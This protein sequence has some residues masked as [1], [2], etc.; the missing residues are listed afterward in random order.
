MTVT[1][2][3]FSLYQP[4]GRISPRSILVLL[5][6]G[7][8]GALLLG[9]FYDFARG[10]AHGSIAATICT[11]IFIVITLVLSTVLCEA[12]HSRSRR[13]N[14]VSAFALVLLMMSVRWYLP[15]QDLL[16]QSNVHGL[17]SL[18]DVIAIVSSSLADHG[19]TANLGWAMETFCMFLLP[20]F[21]AGKGASDPY[22]E[23]AR[24]WAEKHIEAELYW[25]GGNS[26]DVL[27]KLK[28]E[29]VFAMLNM[30]R[31]IDLSASSLAS[32]WWTLK[33]TGKR[34][35]ADPDARWITVQIVTF[36]RESDGKVKSVSDVVL[37]HWHLPVHEY[38]AL[39]DHIGNPA[40]SPPT[41]PATESSETPKELV[42]ALAALQSDNFAEAIELANS[43]AHDSNHL[44]AADARRICAQAHARLSQWQESFG[45]YKRLF[46]LEPSALN[47]LQLA[48]TAV[49]SADTPL[50]DSWFE[51][52][53]AININSNELPQG[54]L[55]TAYLSALEQAGDYAATRPHLDWLACAYRSVKV[56]DDHF[57][58]ARGLPFF[59]EFLKK[60]QP[61][62]LACVPEH[63]V[64]AW[65]EALCPD[66]DEAGR[67]AVKQHL[68]SLSRAEP[69]AQL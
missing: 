29:G 53:Q 39:A 64:R 2:A 30:P 52:A 25:S 31:A 51:R 1:T 3:D 37:E 11:S 20:V 65:Y 63:E 33:I 28:H 40:S 34:V 57:V 41:V 35:E 50:G 69:S 67:A 47:A 49:M 38:D 56:T 18:A 10:H 12:A 43:Y 16:A 32:R 24:R 61:L 36:D 17:L 58:W 14:Q 5:A 54:R 59:G 7:I 6:A 15:L 26:K 8:P 23:S 19:I 9:W 66:L 27:S 60:S 4:S 46:D 62:L 13:F 68:A 22:S 21:V 55:R 42:P 44:I 48:T 45:N